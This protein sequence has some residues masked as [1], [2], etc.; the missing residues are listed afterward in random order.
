MATDPAPLD[1]APAAPGQA[2]APKLEGGNY[3]LLRARLEEDARGLLQLADGLNTQ[4][5]ETFGGQELVVIGNERVRTEHKCVPRN[6]VNVN[7]KLLLAYNVRF[8]LK[9]EVQISDVF[10]LH[11]I[12]EGPEGWDLGAAED[13]EG[14]LSDPTFVTQFK[15]LYQYYR[16]ARVVTLRKT[17]NKLLAVF[18][19]GE[20]A[21]DLRVF[22]WEML[23]GVRPRYIDN[24]GERDHTFPPPHDFDWVTTTREDHE[25]GDHPHVNIADKV[26]VETIGG[27]LTIKVENNT[28][29]GKGIYAEPVNDP[30]QSL[31][32]A[33]IKYALVGNIVLLSIRPFGEEQTRTLLFNTR[34]REV[35]R[36]D[37]IGQACVQLPEDHGIIFPGGYY[38]RSG[39]S[40]IFD[41]RPEGLI[42]KRMVRAP[43]GEDVLYVFHREE[44]GVY[45]LLPYNLIRQEVA[46]PM[47][48]HGYSLF[49]DGRLVI[50]R[51][52]SDEPTRVHPLQIWRT[53]FT[54]D[55]HHANTPAPSGPLGRIGNADLVRGLSEV[56][57]I[58]RLL[59]NLSPS[60]PV[61][62]DLV[63]ATTRVIDHFHWLGAVAEGQLKRTLEQARRNA[64]LIIDEFEKLQA[65]QRRAKEAV[66]G[67]TAA[68]ERLL[69]DCRPEVMA[70]LPAFMDG[71]A[72]LREHRG[73]LITLK[74][75]RL[76]DRAALDAL[77]AATVAAQGALSMGVVSF[78]Q[79]PAALTGITDQIRD[80]EGRLPGLK[81]AAEGAAVAADVDR[82]AQG[83]NLLTEVVGGLEVGDP[84][85]RTAILERISE[86][87]AQLNRVRA[88]LDNRKRE[89]GRVEAQAEFSAQF[90]LLAQGVSSALSL[91]DSPEACDAQR[92]RL[93]VQLEELEGR[94]GEFD[95]FLADIANKREEVSDAFEARRQQLTE[96]RQRRVEALI[97]AATRILEGLNRRARG[98]AAERELAA[99]FASDP[100]VQKVRQISEQ[101]AA[102]GD[103]VKSED[104]A[105]R[106]LAVRANALR[107]IR[108]KLDLF[109]EGAE[110]IKFGQHR[111]AVNTAAVELTLLP[112]G[113]GMA[114]HLTGTGYYEE[115]T[116]PGL[117]STR[118][119]WS[120]SVASED[121]EVYRAEFLAHALL[122]AAEAGAG[123][124]SVAAL[125]EA[126][127]VDGG[128]L[129][130]V[131]AFAA[132]RYD[133]GYE[134]GVHDADATVILE[135]LLGMRRS[136]GL[137]RF[138]ASARALGA[139]WWAGLADREQRAA[140]H[141]QALA[142]ARLLAAFPQ[143]P[144]RGA[145]TAA[146]AGAI[147]PWVAARLAATPWAAAAVPEA[148]AYLAEELAAER[149]R[150]VLSAAAS[151]LLAALQAR[152]EAARQ[153]AALEEDLRALDADLGARLGLVEAWLDALVRYGGD[154]KLAEHSFAA[155]E[156]AAALL[157]D[158]GLDRAPSA[159]ALE[160]EVSG[161]L[162]QH[163]RVQSGKLRLRA[164][165]L[166]P[167]LERFCAVQVPGFAALRA[168]RHAVVERA[169]KA[170]RLDELKPKPMTSFVRNRLINEVYLPLIGNNLAKQLGAAGAGKRTDTM[171]LL[172][173]ISPPGYGK[174]T[175]ME[176]VANVLGLV[177]M[178]VNGPSIGHAVTSL[179]PDQA[180]DATARQEVEKINLAFEMGEN[181]M[182]YLDDI[183]H[184]NPELLQKFISLCD[185]T[186]R[187]EGI[188]KGKSRTYD[189]KGKKF[190]VV[191]A[192]NPYTE[193]GARF[194]IPDMLANRADTYNLGDILGGRQDLF[195]LS[196][197]ENCLT[198]NRVLA[199]LA[200]RPLAD[201]Y[202][203]L[204]R[205]H[206][207]EIDQTKLSADTSAAEQEEIGAVLLR[208]ERVRETL[209]KV[210]AEYI[211]S[212]GIDDKF[213]TEPPFKLQGSYRNMAKLSEKIA[214]AMTPEEVERLV[215]DHYV[216]ESQTLTTGAE[217]NLLKLAVLRGRATP[218]QNER[219]AAI[220]KEFARQRLMGGSDQ[221]PV[222]RV[223]GTLTGLGA[224]L[225]RIDEALRAPGEDRA[226]AALSAALTPPLDALRAELS[227]LRAAAPAAQAPLTT[228]LDAARHEAAALAHTLPRA[229]AEALRS[230]APSPSATPA[231][232]SP[233]PLTAPPPWLIP[234][235][236][237]GAE[238]DMV[239]RH[240]ILAE[241]QRALVAYG[242]M[243]AGAQRQLRAGEYVLSGALP[244]MQAL[245][246][247]VTEQVRQRLPPA[248]Q[249]AFLDELR[250]GIAKAIAQLGQATGEQV[251]P[252]AVQLPLDAPPSERPTSS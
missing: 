227:A 35:R 25:L 109:D 84:V 145:L 81:R 62:E 122:R 128:L 177:F 239:M 210:N 74:E 213:R 11:R 7:G 114:L 182:L 204:D 104:L 202:L 137:L 85:Q 117:L 34:N 121:P 205:A 212:A 3:D 53:P 129:E 201:L 199:P 42:F 98:F 191:M 173:L 92:G 27:D 139:L 106:L 51:A 36:I 196:Y 93:M 60:R 52:E 159:V 48:G 174:T 70:D 115:V 86:V 166:G 26:F 250:R 30:H 152:L 189:L 107:V 44:T 39:V 50:F 158:R 102:L 184:T 188:W 172:L 215:D 176:Y 197:I 14:L 63:R 224:S 248:E 2:A 148:A 78:L 223:T 219:W 135:K 55:E 163:P 187:V 136:V 233:A 69:L 120:M 144:A 95:T 127:L 180:P 61:F 49:D 207:V 87:F 247:L 218:A 245:A 80:V 183:Q 22:R 103:S 178:K 151:A 234:D 141:R 23:P 15:E 221:D 59:G 77:E 241:V 252:S 164:D 57:A 97:S 168:A 251:D 124:L 28:K 40:R 123:G 160:L 4:R 111:F 6:I 19:I 198:S 72:R 101:L 17:D 154:P 16:D 155:R 146:L 110:L 138:S 203:L 20:R 83:L 206:G 125:D 231:A 134:R 29:T 90:K 54:S 147:G 68:Q 132:D 21:D 175:L 38:L 142:A 153:R 82:T 211:R 45:V 185:G 193:T 236:E 100:M 119:F 13:E 195:G 33:Q 130:R 230:L 240:A 65:L 105:G 143:A 67:A 226:A 43:N 71:M 222:A 165:E 171:G 161:L 79:Q 113:E 170:L 216:G 10:S 73:T 157:T 167:R 149:P 32:D 91:A 140:L 243:Q 24:R 232:A 12:V 190:C 217:S 47:G 18:R 9:R 126:L 225:D 88:L 116:D 118:P 150:F 156:A 186:R 31:D 56:L 112:R 46:A 76:V 162:G 235:L 133:E 229:L 246:A 41:E 242:R 96:E 37:A 249:A 169:R 66:E 228:A 75:L 200:A 237:V 181:V 238:A 131:R 99:W 214:S 244:V 8:A 108:D 1:S 89:L 208:M 94:F 58:A 192:G 220:C 179:D 209:L 64:E 194:Q 5:K